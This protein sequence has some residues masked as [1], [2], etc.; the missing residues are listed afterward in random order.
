[1]RYM[2]ELS[3]ADINIEGELGKATYNQ[4]LLG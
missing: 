2:A 1:M 4:N 3:C